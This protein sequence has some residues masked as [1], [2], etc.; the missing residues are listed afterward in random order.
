VRQAG[1]P[2]ATASL[3]RGRGVDLDGHVVELDGDRRARQLLPVGDGAAQ[4][5]QHR[6]PA[7]GA[8]HL[9]RI[10]GARHDAVRQPAGGGEHHRRLAQRG[11]HAPDVVDEPGA[12]ADDQHAAAGQPLA[13]GVEQVG[14]AVQ[15]HRRLPG[16]RA[17]LD[18]DDAGQRQPDDRVLLGLDRA[19]D[20]AHRR[21]ARRLQR[22]EQ[23]RIGRGFGVDPLI[24]HIVVEI[25]DALVGRSSGELEMPSPG[26]AERRGQGRAVERL[27]GGCSPV[28]QGAFPVRRIGEADAADVARRPVGVVEPAE[29]QSRAG[30][31]QRAHPLRPAVHRDVALP[32]GAEL[33]ARRGGQHAPRLGRGRRELGG[34][35]RVQPADPSGLGRELLLEGGPGHALPDRANLKLRSTE[36]VF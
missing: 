23:R 20:V 3:G 19:H 27:G 34:E 30:G 7:L 33:A 24:Q 5:V 6:Q 12:G 29:A 11:E 10:D 31:V 13:V 14:D 25:D 21:S 36:F 9:V 15:R 18:H 8:S 32:A 2:G 35:Q 26:H 22:G 4:H 17:A 16:P 1:G 28:D